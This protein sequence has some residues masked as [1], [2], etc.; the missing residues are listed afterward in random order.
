MRTKALG[1]TVWTKNL[2]D[3]DVWEIKIP[4]SKTRELLLRA[5]FWSVKCWGADGW[6]RPVI[7][8]Q[9]YIFDFSCPWV[10]VQLLTREKR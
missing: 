4:I 5:W 8:R 3:M 7:F 1:V 9:G 6:G 10:A 2:K